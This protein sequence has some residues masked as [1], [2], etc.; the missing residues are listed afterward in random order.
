MITKSLSAVTLTAAL[1]A[2][3]CG[4]ASAMALSVTHVP[5]AVSEHRAALTGAVDPAT[6]MQMQV[7]LPMRNKE[8][9]SEL[10]RAVSTPGNPQ[11]RHYLS[12]AQFTKRF[13]PTKGDYA[14]A[15]KFF[16][17]HELAVTHTFANRYM[18]QI[19][20]SAAN[21]ER[22]LHVKLNLYKHPTE[23]RT[24]MAPDREPTLDLNVPVQEITSLDNY[25][26]PHA[27]LVR[28]NPNGSQRAGTGSGP[29]GNFIASDFRAVYY[30][31]GKKAKLDGTGQSVGLMEL[32]PYNPNDVTLYF[33]TFGPANT[34]PVNGIAVGGGSATCSSC[35]DGEQELDIVY[36]IG[37]APKLAQ[38]QVYVSNNPIAIE[39]QMA[40]DNTSKQLST[41][42]GYSE[43]FSTEDPIYQE[44][45][46]Q[47][48]SWFTAS[49]D[50]STLQRSGPWPEEDAN[51]IAVG[52]TDLVTNGAGGTWK[53][54]PGW[55]DS[56][57]GPSVDQ[58]ILIESYQ[59]PYINKKNLGSKDSSQ[60]FRHFGERELRHDDLRSRKLR[61]RRRWYEFLVADLGRLQRADEPVCVA[62]RRLHCRL[63]QPDGLRSVQGQQKDV[64]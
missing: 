44:M 13:G 29:S 32:G 19:E 11:Y 12:V 58:T 63:P 23:N 57:S 22:T 47:G 43:N 26:L 14:A 5:A 61:R 27:K 28:A 60:C 51:I 6:H 55:S 10:A 3:L 49:G 9:L 21:V 37:M 20:G 64:A 50:D 46:T 45:A 25:I 34:V 56:A 59:L 2:A 18:F 17:A 33:T 41:S 62:E 35:E 31:T 52:G 38:V 39:E 36:P 53:S 1:T 40:S 8:E 48:Q 15:Q 30:G 42:W 54:E 7:V 4:S 24:F 16:A